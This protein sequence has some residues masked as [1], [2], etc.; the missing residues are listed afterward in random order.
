MWL[1]FPLQR[2][3]NPPP[4]F[5]FANPAAIPENGHAASLSLNAMIPALFLIPLVALFRIF[6]AW[7][8]VGTRAARLV[9]AAVGFTPLAAVAVVRGR[10]SCPGGWRW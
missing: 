10:C 1:P 8:P 3:H 4:Q 7:Q 6:L 9:V 2:L 5:R